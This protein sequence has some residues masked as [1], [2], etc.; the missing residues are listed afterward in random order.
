MDNNIIIDVSL[1]PVRPD[2]LWELT[3][4]IASNPQVGLVH[5]VSI[6]TIQIYGIK[7]YLEGHR[8]L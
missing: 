2:S 5:Q 4:H 3:S 8:H 6:A 1:F 7:F